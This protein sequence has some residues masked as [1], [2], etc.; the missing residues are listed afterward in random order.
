[1]LLTTEL[2]NQLFSFPFLTRLTIIDS[3]FDFAYSDQDLS[4]CRVTSLVLCNY[5]QTSGLL[6]F[7]DVISHL[8]KLAELE[9]ASKIADSVFHRLLSSPTPFLFKPETLIIAEHT[10]FEW[11]FRQYQRFFERHCS[12]LRFL[13]VNPLKGP[14]SASL[15][16]VAKY[17]P[18]LRKFHG[19]AD[20]ANCC[21]TPFL[22]ELQLSAPEYYWGGYE[23][24]INA[25]RDLKNIPIS[26]INLQ[27]L[28]LC[29]AVVTDALL[30]DILEYLPN[31]KHLAFLN[32][33]RPR[34][35]LNI[36]IF[37]STLLRSNA[38]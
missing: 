38:V 8:P 18:S 24:G 23:N 29:T 32:I 20:F 7:V 6:N 17:L 35:D 4:S 26:P 9:V 27:K 1:V 14:P 30:Q 3:E 37:P 2:C 15:G 31:L 5:E 36:V 34:L 22:E 25:L 10:R 13:S 12:E 21:V 16:P 28:E 19:P 11:D 33:E